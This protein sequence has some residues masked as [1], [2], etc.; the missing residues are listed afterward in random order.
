MNKKSTLLMM[1]AAA[2]I[3]GGAALA[4]EA[5]PVTPVETPAFVAALEAFL[6]GLDESD[7]VTRAAIE[8]ALADS[9]LTVN[10]VRIEDGGDE[11]R[12]RGT[13]DGE[14]VR[15]RIEDG[16]IVYRIGD[17]NSNGG[18]TSDTSD[19]NG[20][21]TSD[22]SDSNGGDSGGSGGGNSGNG[23]GSSDD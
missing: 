17:D 13:L 6:A 14:R 21:D 19:A 9:G 4:Q 3:T 7:P 5:A 1:T 11:I 15:L 10:R 20:D 23:G 12:I 8:E 22:T 18:D 16:R 2:F